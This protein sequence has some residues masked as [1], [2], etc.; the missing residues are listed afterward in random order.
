MSHRIDESSEVARVSQH[1]V[2]PP[3]TLFQNGW[4]LAHFL[5]SAL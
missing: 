1:N 4:L 5:R 3:P 2:A